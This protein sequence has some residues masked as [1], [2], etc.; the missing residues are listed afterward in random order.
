MDAPTDITLHQKSRVLEVEYADGAV[1]KLPLEYL[2]V[3]SP[4]AEVRGHGGPMQLVT[5][6][7]D[8]GV[9]KIEPVG[10][11]AIQL[12]FDDGHNTGIFSW[13]GLREL[14][15]AYEANWNDYLERLQAAEASRDKLWH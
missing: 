15:D 13:A 7:R 14:G 4:S 8:V 11:Y 9:D 5:G 2:R 12:H 10:N 6:K 3:Y 1:Y